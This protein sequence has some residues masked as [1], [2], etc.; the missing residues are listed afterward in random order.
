MV[1]LDETRA[2]H[3]ELEQDRAATVLRERTLHAIAFGLELC[4][5]DRHGGRALG[6]LGV[7]EVGSAVCY[8]TARMQD[9]SWAVVSGDV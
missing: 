5:H 3:R 7:V 9:L 4:E 2:L 1:A 6:W 8:P